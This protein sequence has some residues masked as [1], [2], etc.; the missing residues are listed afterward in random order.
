MAT[1]KTRGLDS[2]IQVLGDLGGEITPICKMGLYDGAGIIA[3]SI[4][5]ACP[6]GETG[7]LKASFGIARFRADNGAVETII[8]FD[9][10]DSKGVPNQL[11]ARVLESGRP[12]GGKIVG[13]HPFIR[14]AVRSARGKAV[15]AIQS[16]I[17]NEIKKIIGG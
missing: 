1:I 12:V 11:K 9:G 14:A 8:G 16:E 5:A 2:L 15:A 6:T 17:E 13:K 10:Y 4:S 7:D 3:D